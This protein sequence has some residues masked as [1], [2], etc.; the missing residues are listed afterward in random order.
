MERKLLNR[1]LDLNDDLKDNR[2]L[3]VMREKLYRVDVPN[4]HLLFS[5]EEDGEKADKCLAEILVETN[6]ALDHLEI[7]DETREEVFK[8]ISMTFLAM[9]R[10]DI[11]ARKKM[12][13]SLEKRLKDT[14][15]VYINPFEFLRDEEGIEEVLDAIEELLEAS[16]AAREAS[17][18]EI[19]KL[20]EIK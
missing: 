13:E 7:K 9:N 5:A 16:I 6:K 12:E 1:V 15:K 2:T 18:E 14:E 17:T 20:G 11:K 19:Q 3:E 8:K 10:A 4:L